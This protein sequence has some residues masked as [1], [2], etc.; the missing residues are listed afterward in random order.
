MSGGAECICN[1][2]TSEMGEKS[3]E[4]HGIVNLVNVTMKNKETVFQ[5]KWKGMADKEVVL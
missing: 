1:P 4:A 5:T 3:L 2:T